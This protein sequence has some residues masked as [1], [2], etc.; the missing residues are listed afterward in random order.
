ME[1][2]N[3]AYIAFSANDFK[4]AEREVEKAIKE[5]KNY[6]DAW[7][8][9]GDIAFVQNQFTAA[10]AAYQQTLVINP[11]YFYA[12]F[13]L[14]KVAR[15]LKNDDKTIEE[16]EKFLSF[17]PRAEK[18][19]RDA[20]KWMRDA[21]FRKEALKSPIDFNPVNMGAAINTE[22]D[23]YWPGITAD[24]QTFIFTRQ[25]RDENFFI[26]VRRDTA[27]QPAKP[28]GPPVNTPLNEGTVSIS[29]DGLFIFYTACNREGGIGSCDLYFS[30][31]DGQAWGP[32]RNMQKPVNSQHWESTPSVSFDGKTIYFSSNRPGGYGGTDIWFTRFENNRFT[33]PE[34]MGPNINTEGNEE[35]PFIHPD[36]KTMYFSSN[37]HPGMGDYDL[38][39]SRRNP[40]GT[41]SE[42]VNLGY[43]LNN[44]GDERGLILSRS[45]KDA[46]YSTNGLPGFG[47]QDIFRF[48]LPQH[49]R[50]QEA[51]YVKGIVRDKETRKF[52]AA[53]AE[54]IDLSTGLP[55][56]S[57]NSNDKSGTFIVIL[58]PGRDYALNVS[59]TGYL[60][61]SENFSLKSNS[62][63]TPYEL[64]IL[65]TPIKAG[66]V[67]VLRNVFFDVD[68]YD[69]K[70]ESHVELDRAVTLLKQSPNLK[71]EVG[72][73]T[74]NTG[75]RDRNL[76][77]SEN[78]AKAVYDYLIK[79]G[80]PAS[81]LTYK[82]YADLKPIAENNTETGR[83]Q[84]RRTELKLME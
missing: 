37:G 65:L 24:E 74:D 75:Q 29:T 25:V 67:L 52:V 71:V 84:N 83:A 49:L 66:G 41:W 42:A 80:I 59:A 30:K 4:K 34:N 50:P 28:L 26:S 64:E 2:Y 82:G 57:A 53:T 60:F 16:V 23:E 47:G 46:Y 21:R 79:S 13:L 77:L 1:A 33:E 38:F 36:D 19:K 17:Q 43:P 32:P 8:L 73:H 81:R 31:F 27:W 5:D 15:A 78:R 20:E 72:G 11:G 68:K 54:L 44:E 3:N 12:Y 48:S 45:G 69:L 62:A 14:A 40:D 9:K 76:K 61:Y 6:I 22:A 58:Q 10:E 51:G 39:L 63:A 7:I 55:V 35:A 18:P 56:V 70:P